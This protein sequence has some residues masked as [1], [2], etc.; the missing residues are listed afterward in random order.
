M[1]SVRAMRLGFLLALT[2]AAACTCA[3]DVGGV[4]AAEDAGPTPLHDVGPVDGVSGDAGPLDAGPLD[5]GPADAGSDAGRFPYP[6]GCRLPPEQVL[7]PGFHL[8]DAFPNLANFS[9]ALFLTHAG[10][11]SGRIFVVE[12]GGRVYSFANEPG[13]ATRTL[14][15][16]L[17]G[18]VTAGGEMGLLG[19][20]FHPDFETNGHFFVSY[21]RRVPAQGP[22]YSFVSRMTVSANDPSV[23]DTSTEVELLREPQPNTNHNGGM[24]AFGPDGYLYI[25][26]GDGGGGGDPAG[27]GQDLTT[28]LGAIL[29]IDVDA[30]EGELPYAI[31]SDNPFAAAVDGSRREIYAWGLRNP[32]RFSFDRQSGALY[33]ADVGQGGGN[34]PGWEEINRIEA[35]KN[36]GW[37]TME[38]H[39]CYPPSGAQDCDKAGLELPVAT[40]N[41]DV[42]RSITGGYVYRGEDLPALVGKY[43][44]GDY[45]QRTVSVFDPAT[46]VL[47][48]TP[49]AVSPDNIPSFG[50]DEDGE[51]YVLGLN[52]G[53]IRRLVQSDVPGDAGPFP[54]TLSET[55]CFDDVPNLV[56]IEGILPYEP[57]SPLWSDG[58]EK[59]RWLALPAGGLVGFSEDESWDLPVGSTT[60]KHFALDT[61]AGDASTRVA[62]ET[63]FLV[64]EDEGV[65]GYSYRWRVDGSEADLLPGAATRTLQRTDSEGNTTSYT[66]EFPSRAACLRCHVAVAGD[67]LGIE[68]AQLNRDGQIGGQGE[69]QLTALEA[70]GLFSAPLPALPA[71]L[72]RLVAPGDELASYSER[73]RG[74]LHSNCA[75]CHRPGGPTGRP[76]DLRWAT[77]LDDMAACDALPQGSTLMIE[78]ARLL[79]PGDSER[80]LLLRRMRSVSLRMPPLATSLFDDEGL[81]AV[82]GW[83]DE[84]QECP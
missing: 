82:A 16:N 1:V 35:G 32:W 11:A 3:V 18:Q 47:D 67:A 17:E 22:L 13:V 49:I 23:G 28:A 21:T 83:I 80:S 29:R 4:D 75:S 51:L 12:R 41:H 20:A 61:T 54:Q 59:R 38:G 8:E 71:E 10:D 9:S 31:P 24:I 78:D 30:T 48:E 43:L 74:Y 60:I 5:A 40:Y 45:V 55:G 33:A 37:N 2:C 44:F 57:L 52:G 27:N 46:G 6:T 66:W 68:T 7:V 56:P 70:L 63:R 34:Q 42:G 79:V 39:F 25:A 81:A 58:T 50:E 73:A 14:F 72:P 53:R 36:Y 26:L 19:L 69:N 77:A 65:R 64:V 15:V 62:L 76:L 84:L